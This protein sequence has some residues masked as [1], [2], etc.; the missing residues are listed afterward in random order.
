VDPLGAVTT[1]V[2]RRAA[3]GTVFIA[4]EAMTPQAAWRAMIR[5]RGDVVGG[6]G[7]LTPG[8][9]ADFVLLDRDPFALAPDDW[10]TIQVVATF[11]AGEQVWP[12]P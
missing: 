6:D 3:S 4:E 2:T 7:A 10:P 5:G 11:I 1:A 12:A 9:V 8:S